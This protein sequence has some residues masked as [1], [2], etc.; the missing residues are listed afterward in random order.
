MYELASR[1]PFFI[2]GV[3]IACFIAA[4]T[5]PDYNELLTMSVMMGASKNMLKPLTT[6]CGIISATLSH[7]IKKELTCELEITSIILTFFKKL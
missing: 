1:P 5:T 2:I 3:T 7:K 6:H 4:G